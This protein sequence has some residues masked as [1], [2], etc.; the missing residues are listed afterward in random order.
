MNPIE[1]TNLGLGQGRSHGLISGQHK[2]FNELMG[3]IALPLMEGLNMVFSI[4][5]PRLRARAITPEGKVLDSFAITKKDGRPGK[6]YLAGA[7]AGGAAG[8]SRSTSRLV[9]AV[10]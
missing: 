7:V 2:F 3:L 6:A 8:V 9:R 1:N 5:G 4:D 10:A